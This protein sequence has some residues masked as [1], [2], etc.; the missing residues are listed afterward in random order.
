MDFSRIFPYILLLELESI[1]TRGSCPNRDCNVNGT[2]CSSPPLERFR[3]KSITQ[4]KELEVAEMVDPQSPGPPVEALGPRWNLGH[5]RSTPSTRPLPSA[6][7]PIRIH[8][9][10]LMRFMNVS[11]NGAEP[12]EPAAAEGHGIPSRAVESNTAFLCDI[13]L[14]VEEM[15][16]RFKPTP[17]AMQFI[18]TQIADESRGRRLL[19]SLIEKTWFGIAARS[20]LRTDSAASTQEKD[21]MAALAAA[22]QIPLGQ[23]EGT[24]RVLMEYLAYTGILIPSDRGLMPPSETSNLTAPP[25]PDVRSRAPAKPSTRKLRP[26]DA[27][28]TGAPNEI[29]EWEVIQTSEFYLRI[30]PSPSAL[31]RLRKQLD[32]LDQKL[33]EGA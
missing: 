3:E 21:L 8:F 15:T 20:L 30:Q 1:G 12:V 11:H 31:K 29:A 5:D 6:E 7:F 13:G 25:Y 26:E 19:R 17:V 33:K 24:L 2:H 27:S 14:L 18:N 9:D 28:M 10:I 16:G 32:L 22:A 23:R 4:E